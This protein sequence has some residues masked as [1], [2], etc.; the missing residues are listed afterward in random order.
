ML[1]LLLGR[2]D[3]A[4]KVRSPAFRRVVL[5]PPNKRYRVT[6]PKHNLPYTIAPG[7]SRRFSANVPPE[8]SKIQRQPIRFKNSVRDCWMRWRSVAVI[9]VVT[10]ARNSFDNSRIIGAG[11]SCIQCNQRTVSSRSEWCC[12]CCC[13]CPGTTRVSC[14]VPGVDGGGTTVSSPQNRNR[15]M[16][17]CN[18]KADFSSTHDVHPV[19]DP[20]NPESRFKSLASKQVAMFP[21]RIV[22]AASSSLSS[23]WSV[24]SSERPGSRVVDRL[25]GLLVEDHRVL[26]DPARIV[27]PPP[28][29]S[30][31]S[32]NA[33]PVVVHSN[34][35]TSDNNV[36]IVHDHETDTEVA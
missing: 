34:T 20:S 7:S 32:S 11:E 24:S 19:D 36:S 8:G 18:R 23:S 5:R 25:I 6:P 33:L 13:C 22:H 35:P 9:S 3:G 31:R 4:S 16:H 14:C 29:T 26:R 2:T 10:A 17:C 30:L 28:S 21:P 12:C 15:S 27:P 1:R